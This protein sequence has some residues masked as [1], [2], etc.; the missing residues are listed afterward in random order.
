MNFQAKTIDWKY[1]QFL[2]LLRFICLI[3]STI[4]GFIYLSFL[5]NVPNDIS[6]FEHKYIA[7]LSLSLVLFNNPFSG[8]SLL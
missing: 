5:K 6:T 1:I 2:I 4:S 7:V 3:I 8:I